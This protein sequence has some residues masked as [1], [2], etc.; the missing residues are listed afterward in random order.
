MKDATKTRAKYLRDNYKLTIE[1]WDIIDAFQHGVC[2]LCG[3]PNASGKRLSTDHRHSD[4]LIRGLLCAKCNPL[5]GKLENAFVRY[6]LHKIAGVTLVGLISR[7]V[8]YLS[9]PP[10]TEALGKETFGY[11]GRTGTKKHRKLLKRLA[12]KKS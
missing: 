7:L 6:G 9:S 5:L 2:F 11:P 3:K 4:G 8:L 10:A 12:K 1:Q